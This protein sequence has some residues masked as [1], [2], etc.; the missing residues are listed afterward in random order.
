VTRE[1]LYLDMMQQ[2]LS[3]A[4]KIMIDQEGGNNLLYLPLD[5]LVQM[6]ESSSAPASMS[7]TQQ[8]QSS[9]VIQEVAPNSTVRG[10]ES[11]RDRERETR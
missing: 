3:N 5:K 9:P 7:G 4:S 6:S 8:Q 1:R 2:V 11:F 10:R